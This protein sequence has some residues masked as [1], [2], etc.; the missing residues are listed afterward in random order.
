VLPT[1]I[2]ERYLF[3]SLPFLILC[4][5]EDWRIL[6]VFITLVVTATINIFGA[7]PGFGPQIHA[8][9]VASPL[10][11]ICA[12]V[13]L[14]VLILMMGHFL[15]MTAQPIH[16]RRRLLGWPRQRPTA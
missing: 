14:V 11:V 16:G 7:L 3:L 6:V 8:L 1:Q 12:M 4:A 2:H 10:P 13:N 5:V 15:L 9:I